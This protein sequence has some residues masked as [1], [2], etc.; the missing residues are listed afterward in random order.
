MDD[1]AIISADQVGGLLVGRAF[2]LAEQLCPF[3]ELQL[4]TPGG[5]FRRSIVALQSG[6][7]A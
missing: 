3:P 4:A 6:V 2:I 1:L 5:R 7:G